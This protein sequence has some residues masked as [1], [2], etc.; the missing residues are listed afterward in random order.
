MCQ[1]SKRGTGVSFTLW[2]YFDIN[3]IG[4]KDGVVG[5]KFGKY[6]LVRKLAVGGMAEIFLATH[7]GPEGFKKHVA[8][9]RILPHLTEDSDFVTMFLDEAR[10]VARFNHPNL[11]QIFELGQV[12]DNYFL[13]M[14]YVQ[15]TSM[16][17]VLKTCAKRQLPFPLEYGAK[18]V[19]YACEGLEYAHNFTDPDGSS[20][21]LIHRDVSPQNI[22]LSYDGVVKVLDFGIAKAAGNLYQTRTTSL[23][24]KAAYMSPE[25]ITQKSGMD[26][27][28]DIFSLGIVLFEYA[29]GK[30]PFDGDTEL[31]LMMGIVQSS[32]TDPREYEPNIP[33][34]L[35]KIMMTA[36]QKDRRARYQSARELRADLELFL[37]NR[38]MMVDSY[39]LSNFLREVLPQGESI[40][41]Y[42]VPTPSRPSLQP[43]DMTDRKTD[44]SPP[45]RTPMPRPGTGRRPR[46]EVPE[47]A[48]APTILTPSEVI[49]PLVGAE[50]L[51][52]DK[53][54]DGAE[55]LVDL[56][57][58][59]D[60]PTEEDPAAASD[61]DR[62]SMMF[63][64]VGLAIII[65][66]GASAAFLFFG[67]GN[68]KGNQTADAGML[69]GK[70]AIPEEPQ[71]LPEDA[72]VVVAKTSEPT[73]RPDAGLQAAA[74]PGLDA[75]SIAAVADKGPRVANSTYPPKKKKRKRRRKRIIHETTP[76][77]KPPDQP[78][79]KPDAGVEVAVV[80][81]K[82]SVMIYS[83]P[84]T[85][86]SID[87]TS[88]GST[89]IDGPISLS[90]GKHIVQLANPAKGIKFR[91]RIQIRAGK[92]HNIRKK[93]RKGFL[94]V[95]VKPF[96]KVYVDGSLKGQTPL[97]DDLGLYEGTHFLRVTCTRTG[98]ED[99]RK[100]KIEPGKT[101]TVKLDLR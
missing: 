6:E 47:D 50:I 70:P 62:K 4:K 97:G 24:G 60:S 61:A 83:Q 29:T 44:R 27:R 20:L 38:Q 18:I 82:G 57:L 10:L 81:N 58:P 80:Q 65:V 25:Q 28:S 16:S 30:R 36:L 86:V 13:A 22:M 45:R 51:D 49:R 78:K 54:L 91:Q 100:I 2:D 63:T 3:S 14:E 85:E 64:I 39:T 98:K 88:Y 77:V 56:S 33:E 71:R 41:G 19:S 89:P 34:D 23:K 69:I 74:D 17:K 21:N 96:G 15:G 95:F 1:T 5:E 55:P 66:L 93:F 67:S 31:E 42:S 87:G 79:E 76:P 35:V 26:R 48:D 59:K 7:L 94:K 73:L 72:G 101:I 12:K 46:P 43:D 52:G 11:V 92:K 40:T 75:G 37:L 90:S 53:T 32:P 99:N 8:I 84:W 9:K 68:G